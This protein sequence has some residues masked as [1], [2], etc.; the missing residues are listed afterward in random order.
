MASDSGL[1]ETAPH[2]E[3]ETRYRALF[4]NPV[5]GIRISSVAEGARIVEAN[6]AYQRMLGYSAAEL[7]ERT[8]FDLT[9][10]ED[11]QRNRALYSALTA[12]DTPSYQI[13]KRFVR[14]DGSVF[15]GRLTVHPLQDETGRATHHIGLVEDVSEHRRV[16]EALQESTERLQAVLNA[17]LDGIVLINTVGLIQWVNPAVETM[18]GYPADELRGK[19]VKVLMPQPWRDEHDGYIARYRE[20][21]EARIIGIGR[22]VEGR[23]RDGSTF[24]L[25]LAVSEVRHGG[26][27]FFLGTLRDITERVQLEAEIRQAQ[28][29]EAIGRLAGGV[30]H[31]FNT[32]L[33]TIRGYSEILLSALPPEEPLHRHAEQIHRAALRGAQLTRQLLLFSRRQEPQAQAVDPARLLADVEV[34]L[35]RLIGEDIRLSRRV[36]RKLRRV[37]GDPGEL[38]QI[39]LNL[40][41]NACDAMPHGG[42]LSLSLANVDAESEIAVESGRLPP[43]RYVLLEVADTGTGMSEEVKRRIFE[44]FFTTKEPGKGTGLGLSTVHAIVRRSKGG[45]A[46][47]SRL[48]QGTAFRIYLPSAGEAEAALAPPLPEAGPA[49]GETAAGRPAP[50]RATILLVEDDAMFRGLLKQVLEG[51]GYQTLTA[52]SPAAALELAAAHGRPIELLLSDMIMPGGTGTGLAMDL[53]RLDPAVKVVL[54]S[55]YTDDALASREVDPTVADAFLEKPFATQELLR[56]VRQLLAAPAAGAAGSP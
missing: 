49:V 43:G 16:Q 53:R 35:D 33:G 28:K 44:P 42:A 11:V 13:E 32:L 19:N 22:Q 3:R 15:W 46:V 26:E 5:I 31:D 20:T 9:H 39:L 45:I 55:G 24:P 38:H 1:P 40:I 30:A 36:E 14:K 25:D 7:A 34:M 47:D 41:V 56:R 8:V 10:P 4:E 21:G 51:Q 18:F 6:A 23:R 54:M 17:A 52:E 37:W 2:F 27:V 48:G 12:G 29:M 50:S